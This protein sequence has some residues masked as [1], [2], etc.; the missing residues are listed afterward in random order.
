MDLISANV[1]D[2]CKNQSFDFNK[3]AKLIKVSKC[4][5]CG[6]SREIWCG[7]TSLQFSSP[8][9][10][11]EDNNLT[12]EAKEYLSFFKDS[13]AEITFEP[14]PVRKNFEIEFDN[15]GAHMIVDSE[16]NST[17]GGDIDLQDFQLNSSLGDI[18]IN[19]DQ[20]DPPIIDIEGF[21]GMGDLPDGVI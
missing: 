8:S 2:N 20:N 4:R 5:E 6:D 11:L 7:R 9:G 14:E 10:V 1:L 3:N 17:D 16:K 13:N 12:P 18:E 21:G 15:P 19:P